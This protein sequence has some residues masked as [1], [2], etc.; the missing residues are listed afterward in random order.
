MRRSNPASSLFPP[1]RQDILAA[2]YGQ[3]DRWWFLSELAAFAGKTPSSLQRELRSLAT[4]GIL[5][6]KRDGNRLYFQAEADSPIFRPLRELI[7]QTVGVVGRLKEALTQLKDK[8]DVAFI[9]G[10]VARGDEHA[11]SDIDLMIVGPAGLSDLSA[12]LRPL[13]KALVREVNATCY[14]AAEF[15]EK[16]RSAS[17]FLGRVMDAEKHFLIGDP[18]ELDRIVNKP[19][20]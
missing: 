18:D 7:E 19:D 3:P 9:Y 1:I 20:G 11:L 15:A 6:T 2:T 17:H 13:E 4:S 14:T 5:R 10:S 12:V 16:V 8:I